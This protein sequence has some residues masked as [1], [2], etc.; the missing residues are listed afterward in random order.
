M[1]LLAAR[2][3]VGDICLR[4]FNRAGEQV[5]TELNERV[6]SIELSELRKVRQVVGVAGGPRKHDAIEG[7]LTGKLV[8][9]LITDF[10]TAE[11][12]LKAEDDTLA[13][14]GKR[15]AKTR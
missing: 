3:A 9:V 6:I 4:F 10:A 13:K 7:A 1:K 2:G 8:N 15:T 11:Y 12:L 14:P 5:V